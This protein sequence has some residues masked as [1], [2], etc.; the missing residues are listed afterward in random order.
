M[1]HMTRVRFSIVGVATGM[2]LLVRS[3]R[4]QSPRDA[5]RDLT[6]ADLVYA[7][8]DTTIGW[9]TYRSGGT[10]RG[11]SARRIAA[12]GAWDLE[13]GNFNRGIRL[14]QAAFRFGVADSAF[15]HDAFEL[16]KQLRFPTAAV[17]RVAEVRRRS[18]HDPWIYSA[19]AQAL[20]SAT[21]ADRSRACPV[22][23]R[24]TSA[25]K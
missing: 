15:Y 8:R 12:A 4:A 19:Y 11:D 25:S 6:R 1:I 7:T 24:E 21:T 16:L 17:V 20:R 22:R 23:I 10:A 18:A 9:A 14:I 3:A 13:G 2:A 5:T